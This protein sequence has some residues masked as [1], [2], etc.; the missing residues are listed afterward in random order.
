MKW[1]YI[2]VI[3]VWEGLERKEQEKKM[4]EE[5]MAEK[6]PMVKTIAL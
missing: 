4:S 3:G 6:F 1:S 5:I 2:C